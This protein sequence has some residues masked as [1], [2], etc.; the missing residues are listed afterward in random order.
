MKRNGFTLLELMVV[1]AIVGILA[2]V[3]LPLY[4]DYVESA[5]MVKVSA[6]Y[7]QAVKLAEGE[8][9]RIQSRLAI[10]AG[11]TLA[12][13]LPTGAGFIELLNQ[14][15][16]TAPGGGLA[17]AE[18]ESIEA[19]T[20]GVAISGAGTA[21]TINISRPAYRELDADTRIIAWSDL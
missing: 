14:N 16:G 8:L 21:F 5:N 6:H 3:A 13:L 7:D 4:Q 12:E 18:T 19:G 20:V 2:S 9:R 15:G 10:G 1:L 17:Y 11:T